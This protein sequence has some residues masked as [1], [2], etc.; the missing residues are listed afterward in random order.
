MRL[1]LP[2]THTHTHTH[3]ISDPEIGT[4]I[5]FADTLIEVTLRPDQCFVDVSVGFIFSKFYI[6][7]TGLVPEPVVGIGAVILLKVHSRKVHIG[8]ETRLSVPDSIMYSYC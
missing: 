5:V 3:K 2:P 1:P 4:V 6:K 7:R 8:Y